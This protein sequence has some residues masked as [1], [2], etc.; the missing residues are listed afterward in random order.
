MCVCCRSLVL[1]SLCHTEYW[2]GGRW[3]NSSCLA[4][5][6]LLIIFSPLHLL[7]MSIQMLFLLYYKPLTSADN[8]N[9]LPPPWGHLLWKQRHRH[10][11]SFTSLFCARGACFY[12]VTAFPGSAWE[13][14][15]VT[16]MSLSE[17]ITCTNPNCPCSRRLSVPRCVS[18]NAP[19]DDLMSLHLIFTHRARFQCTLHSKNLS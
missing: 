17:C 15:C 7:A 16:L 10:H 8:V 19:I 4:L 14:Q 6:M 1:Y 18:L 11:F 12:N 5:L 13:P 9:C 3:L 2:L